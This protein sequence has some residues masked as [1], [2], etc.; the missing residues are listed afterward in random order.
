M[1]GT[2]VCARLSDEDGLVQVIFW[3]YNQKGTRGVLTMDDIIEIRESA[4]I[5][6][7]K[8]KH[9]RIKHTETSAG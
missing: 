5:T 1:S 9:N 3:P 6:R 8:T 2:S 7:S 4:R